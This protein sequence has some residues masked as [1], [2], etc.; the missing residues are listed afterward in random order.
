LAILGSGIVA[1]I[2]GWKAA[3]FFVGGKKLDAVAPGFELD[4]TPFAQVER[5]VL[6]GIRRQLG[7]AGVADQIQPREFAFAFFGGH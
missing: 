6:C 3:E 5:I 2:L 4:L 1:T 7:M